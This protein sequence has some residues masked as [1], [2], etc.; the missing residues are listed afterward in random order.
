MESGDEPVEGFRN[1]WLGD[2]GEVRPAADLEAVEFGA[3]GFADV[4]RGAAERDPLTASRH[5]DDLQ[6]LCFEPGHYLC[7][8]VSARSEALPELFR[9]ELTV[10]IGRARRLLS[11]E[12]SFETGGGL[13][14]HGDV[15]D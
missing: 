9:R 2:V 7:G 5:R 1:R 12:K 3:E 14:D 8:I 11:G 6:L 4:C 15:R 10:I 13:Q